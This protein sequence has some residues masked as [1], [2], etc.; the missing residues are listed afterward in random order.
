MGRVPGVKNAIQESLHYTSTKSIFTI[1][2]DGKV[3][4]VVTFMS[5]VTPKDLKLQSLVFS[6]LNVE[7]RP[8]DGREHQVELYSDIS[9]GQGHVWS[10]SHC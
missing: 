3:R 8:L 4:L 1:D 7:V 2:V 6:Y 10:P 9:A 5:P